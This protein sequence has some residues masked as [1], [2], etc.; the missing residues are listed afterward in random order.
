MINSDLKRSYLQYAK[1]IKMGHIKP[2]LTQNLILS[3]LFFIIAVSSL[4]LAPFY[5]RHKNS[6]R[7]NAIINAAKT[8]PLQNIVNTLQEGYILPSIVTNKYT[9]PILPY[10]FYVDILKNFS[11][12]RNKLP[13]LGALSIKVL[14]Y[15]STYYHHHLDRI[16]VFQE[17]SFYM[18]YLTYLIEHDGGKVINIMHGIPGKEAAYFRFSRAHVWGDFFKNFYINNHADKNQF[19]ISGSIYH[20]ILQE[21]SITTSTYD[22]VYFMQG[23]KYIEPDELSDVLNVLS[24]LSKIYRVALKQH[25]LYP[26]YNTNGLTTIEDYSTI[27]VLHMTS[28]ILSHF[29]TTLLD[30][31]VMS[32][33]TFAYSKVNRGNLLSFL[34][35]HE[36]ISTKTELQHSLIKAIQSP[37]KA[38]SLSANFMNLSADTLSLL[39]YDLS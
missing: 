10:F 24:H 37:L 25:P 2:N 11:F 35:E 38:S 28:I 18:S 13:F 21:Q 5:Y 7:T 23:E 32:K 22:I 34:S 19:I 4:V 20:K 1:H 15:Y 17:Y 6:Q 8:E 36:I 33:H 26:V 30:A 3:F 16:I 9:L 27:E 39:K 29:S 31:K 12:Y 14:Q